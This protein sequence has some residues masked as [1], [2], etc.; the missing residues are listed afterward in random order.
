M[1]EGRNVTQTLF[2]IG[3]IVVSD[4]RKIEIRNFIYL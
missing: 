4:Y 1:R 2:D 3:K